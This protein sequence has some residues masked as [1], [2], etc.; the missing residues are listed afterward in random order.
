MSRVAASTR[1]TRRVGLSVA[2]VIVLVSAVYVVVDL[3]RWE[4]NR[5]VLAALVCVA[6]LVVFS[7]TLILGHLTR[8]DQRL[9]EVARR[10]IPEQ[11]TSQV[12][13]GFPAVGAAHFA[14]LE[15]ERDRGVFVPILL[16][17]GAILSFLASVVERIS[18][19]IA[20]NTLG[21]GELDR[22]GVHLP[23]GDATVAVGHVARPHGPRARRVVVAILALVLM[24]V[25]IEGLRQ[26][27]QS[28][29]GDVMAEGSTIVEVVVAQRRSVQAPELVVVELWGAC[30]SRLGTGVSPLSVAPVGA[31]RVRLELDRA[32]GTT[33]RRR[34]IGCI[35]DHTLDLVRADVVALD[36]HPA[37]SRSVP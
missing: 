22:L 28:R 36:V 33:G 18:G 31:G 7:T 37:Q 27:T 32:L 14:W 8:L 35:Q 13:T 4:W 9:D 11:S 15:P 29:A 16:G 10:S 2:F 3:M 1:T 25:S 20:Q 12:A 19:A 23:L 24:A 17:A 26:L 5:A 6:A 30:R 21:P 34:L